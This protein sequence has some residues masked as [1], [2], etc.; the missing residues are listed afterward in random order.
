MQSVPQMYKFFTSWTDALA[1]LKTC[2]VHE[3]VCVALQT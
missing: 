2:G 3:I 1:Y